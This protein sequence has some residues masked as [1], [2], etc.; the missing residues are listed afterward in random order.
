MP[1]P[2]LT[3]PAPLT[4][5]DLVYTAYRLA[6]ILQ[7]PGGGYSLSEGADGLSALNGLLGGWAAQRYTIMALLQSSFVL[8]AN[9]QDYV[10]GTDTSLVT[11]DIAIPRPPRIQ[12]AGLIFTNVTPNVETPLKIFHDQEWEA[13]SPKGLTSSIPWGLW[14]RAMMPAKGNNGLITIWPVPQTAWTI[15]LYTQNVLQQIYALTQTM[16]MPPEYVEAITYNLALRLADLNPGRAKLTS[17]VVMQASA[18][19]RWLKANNA[20]PV[21]MRAEPMRKEQGARW[22][23]FTGTW[24]R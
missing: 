15:N 2:P 19:L 14:Y 8:T 18:S 23:F 4:G 11:P 24:S 22:N 1:A 21:L 20:Q 12:A 9:Q 3:T 13:V 17:R 10:I 7:R 16:Y 6:G 5:E